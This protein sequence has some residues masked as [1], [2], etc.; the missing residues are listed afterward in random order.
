M[1]APAPPVPPSTAVP[2]AAPASSSGSSS[3]PELDAERDHLATARAA[4]SRMRARTAGLDASAGGDG[5][6][7]QLLESALA[8]RVRALADDPGVPLFFGRLDLA[9]AADGTG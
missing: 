7:R 9:R 6:S 3:A 5:V 2:D 1:P 4:L 8:R